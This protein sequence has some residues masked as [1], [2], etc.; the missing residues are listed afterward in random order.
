[1]IKKTL[2][3]LVLLAFI[4][5]TFAQEVRSN[6]VEN[7]FWFTL[8]TCYSVPINS[9]PVLYTSFNYNYK[10]NLFS[11]RYLMNR[12]LPIVFQPRPLELVNEIGL[13][14]GR[15]FIGRGISMSASGVISCIFG[16]LRGEGISGGW[17]SSDYEKI[18]VVTVGAPFELALM[19][20]PAKV[21]GF[22][23][24][25]FGNLNR[26]QSYI[27]IG[28]NASAGDMLKLKEVFG[29]AK[30]RRD[31]LRM[32]RRELF[33]S[34]P[35]E[36]KRSRKTSRVV[37]GV[38]TLVFTGMAIGCHLRAHSS[39]GAAEDY[40]QMRDAST[41][42]ED[43]D[44]YDTMYEEE[45]DLIRSRRIIGNISAGLGVVGIAGFAFSF[46]I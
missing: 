45:K 25:L 14:Y 16:T 40:R 35:E 46:R 24:N 38:G 6:K 41:N 4:P 34:L 1:M 5:G 8:G 2:C 37:F 7:N 10:K 30:A 21:F 15:L 32:V 13:L 12:E 36:V 44:K 31:S 23:F 28:F 19:I 20:A 11:L 9:A 26:E 3:L 33:E 27:G 42:P 43:Y 39:E 22:G 17:F 29:T 18:Q